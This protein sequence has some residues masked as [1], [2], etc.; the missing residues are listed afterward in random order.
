MKYHAN[1]FVGALIAAALGL[2]ALP[3]PAA[4]QGCTA[5]QVATAVDQAGAN[6]R[7]LTQQNQPRID[8]K[9]AELKT[10]RGWTGADADDQAYQAISD[11]RT[12]KLDEQANELLARIDTLGVIAPGAIPE[13]GRIQELEAVSLELQATVRAK[14]NYTLTRLDN[15]LGNAIAVAP[16]ASAPAPVPPPAAP[17][18]APKAAA[19]WATTTTQDPQALPPVAVAPPPPVMPPVVPAAGVEALPLPPLDDGYAIDDIVLA[20]TGFFGKVSAGLGSIIEHAFSRA[21]RPTG[22]ILGTE[23]EARS[24]PACATVPARSI[25]ARAA[26]CRSIGTVPRSAPTSA[27]RERR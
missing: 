3:T 15:L 4:A 2:A 18:P 17:R 10:K 8:A 1:L 11:A 9:I 26:P 14:S 27:L 12:T 5:D 22:Y 13:C 21:G 24:S 25:C 23:G 19:P 16:V 7:R 6:L 20:S